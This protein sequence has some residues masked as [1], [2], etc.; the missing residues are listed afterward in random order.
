MLQ[1]Q[2]RN[3]TSEFTDW[4]SY[5]YTSHVFQHCVTYQHKKWA[6]TPQKIWD[7]KNDGFLNVYFL[8]NMA[9]LGIHVSFRG[10]K[11]II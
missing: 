5:F 2:A 6:T 4:N 11:V 9:I 7:T 8:S 3:D 1:M 10:C